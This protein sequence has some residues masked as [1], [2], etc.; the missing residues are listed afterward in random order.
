MRRFVS[1]CLNTD[2]QRELANFKKRIDIPLDK[3]AS[4]ERAIRD[5]YEVD[6]GTIPGVDKPFLMQPGAEKILFW[7]TLK[8][9]FKKTVIDLNGGHI[10]IVCSVDF[11][12]KRT[13]EHVFE[14]PECSC[15]TMEDNYRFRYAERDPQ[16]DARDP[17]VKAELD[18]LKSAKL[19]LWRKKSDWA[20]GKRVGESWVWLDRIENP[21]IW[22]ERNKVRQIG[23]K[24]ALVKA[25]R[26]MAAL[27]DIFV[28][29]PAEWNIP[30]EDEFGSP[31]L[32]RQYTQGGRRIV[33]EEE[34]GAPAP[35]VSAHDAAF[36]SYLG[37]LTP[38]QRK[39][40][41]EKLAG[42][43]AREFNDLTYGQFKDEIDCYE[44][45]GPGVALSAQG[46][47]LRR[48][49]DPRRGAFIVN[50]EELENLKYSFEQRKVPFK[51]RVSQ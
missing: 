3:R 35:P 13:G 1:K 47:L 29:D 50:G 42:M 24:R 18:K 8:P 38:E 19:G 17:R 32:D 4:E 2:L 6:W 39:I 20:H 9:A 7:L 44:I 10:E 31:E 11:Y 26:N 21:N 16:P 40:E 46:D 45:Q 27:S 34:P 33:R 37:R 41:E 23:Q 43:R 36:E 51:P 15:T 25:V 30:D 48:F 22:Q 5:R 14:G 12:A 49:W 28:S